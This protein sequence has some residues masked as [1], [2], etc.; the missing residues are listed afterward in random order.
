MIMKKS[1]LFLVCLVVIV[2]FISMMIIK[3]KN[4]NVVFNES[5]TF[6]KAT[7]DRTTPF[8]VNKQK[9]LSLS[10]KSKIEKGELA[11]YITNPEKKI[12]YSKEGNILEDNIELDV[13]KGV[14]YYTIQTRNNPDNI[15]EK[16]SFTLK[17]ELK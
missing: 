13:S 16:G 17:G 5:A 1:T 10:L 8:V 6:G 7:I 3:S 4:D 9:K 2:I 12:V 15:D 11:I 14:W